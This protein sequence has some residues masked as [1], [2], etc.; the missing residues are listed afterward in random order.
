VTTLAPPLPAR[1]GRP[2]RIRLALFAAVT[3]LAVSNVVSNRLWPQGYLV[4]NLGMTAV[5][6]HLGATGNW[7]RTAEE[8]WMFTSSPPSSEMGEKEAAWLAGRA[9]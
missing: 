3:L 1:T 9:C 4:W 8:M 7:R 2:V 5:M 6:A